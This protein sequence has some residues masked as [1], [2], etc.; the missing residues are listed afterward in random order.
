MG[1][2]G[3]YRHFLYKSDFFMSR[4]EFIILAI[5]GKFVP[6]IKLLGFV[7][8]KSPWIHFKR[9]IDE[10]VLYFIKSG[11]IHIEENGIRYELKKGDLFLLEPHMDHEGV[12]KHVCDYYYIHFDHPNVQ[13]SYVEDI[14]LLAK[15]FILEE[16]SSPDLQDSDICYF[17]KHYTLSN[18]ISL[19]HGFHVMNELM[20][21]Y[22]RKHFNRSLIALNFFEFLIEI[23]REYLM[24]ELQKENGK[25]SKAFTKVH[26]LLDYIYQFYAKK[27]T[28]QVIEREF[29]CNY[30]YI[31]RV[32]NKVTGHS[33]THYVN[34]VRINHAKELLKATHLSIGEIGYLTGLND[35]YYFSKV[36]KKYVGLSP[37]QYYKK[38]RET[39]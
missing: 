9:N 4:E 14:H 11:E 34:M 38:I 24:T 13:S 32:F 20:Q 6:R 15:R 36:F 5:D 19:H 39:D 23:S 8:Y 33:I 3:I 16:D 37:I 27:I 17:P 30:D 26:A 22:K 12:E 10:Y 28:S 29:E 18:K 25:Y 35:P 2:N 7:S 21:L 1:V 31:N